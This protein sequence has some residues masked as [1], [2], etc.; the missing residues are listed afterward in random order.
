VGTIKESIA[1]NQPEEP[2]P[3]PPEGPD[4]YRE[5]EVRKKKQV[6][7]VM[8]IDTGQETPASEG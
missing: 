4:S 2:N 1:S 7:E 3:P 8:K 5:G 6:S